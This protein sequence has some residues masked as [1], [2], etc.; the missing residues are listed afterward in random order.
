VVSAGL[1]LGRRL[2]RDRVVI[3]RPGSS[4]RFEASSR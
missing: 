1:L 4:G 3:Y 2:A